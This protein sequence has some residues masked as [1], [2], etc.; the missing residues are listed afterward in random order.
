M[1]ILGLVGFI[2]MFVLVLGCG[3]FLGL[4]REEES[5]AV[6]DVSRPPATR[7]AFFAAGK[8]Q[9]LTIT[10][11][12]PIYPTVVLAMLERHVRNERA[13]AEDFL[14]RPTVESLLLET[15]PVAQVQ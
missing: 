10:P 8:G 5:G 2:G 15:R 13:A 1:E 3:L 4:V 7:S 6:S 14:S 9:E 11:D 12:D